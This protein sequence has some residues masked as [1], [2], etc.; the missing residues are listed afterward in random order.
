MII[1]GIVLAILGFAYVL[2]GFG[3]AAEWF[4]DDHIKNNGPYSAFTILIVGLFGGALW[5]I[6]FIPMKMYREHAER[7]AKEAKRRKEEEIKKLRE[8]LGRA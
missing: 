8:E 5:P 7:M 3:V 2:V 4:C 1:I 6:C